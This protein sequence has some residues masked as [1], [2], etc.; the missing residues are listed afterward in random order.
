MTPLHPHFWL[1]AEQFNNR[2]FY[3]CHD[4]FEAI[5]METLDD[6]TFY[7]GLLQIA[8]ALY[9]LSNLNWQ[10]AT[11]L[12]GEGTGRLRPYLP[13]HEGIDVAQVREQAQ[14]ILAR[15]HADGKP[16]VAQSAAAVIGLMDTDPTEEHTPLE[17]LPL[18][19]I[20]KVA[21]S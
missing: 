21:E 13:D 7:Q 10:G 11:T 9:H 2:E 1:G 5:W 12:L 4:T 19:K 14:A 15:L 20:R 8:V 3:A 18:P 6:R 17:P 16:A